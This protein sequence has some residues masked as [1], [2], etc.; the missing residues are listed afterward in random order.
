[1]QCNAFAFNYCEWH[2]CFSKQTF[3]RRF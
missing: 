1:M 3:S 2:T